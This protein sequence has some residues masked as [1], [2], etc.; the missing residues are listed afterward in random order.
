MKKIVIILE[1]TEA[2]EI[3]LASLAEL[4]P[5]FEI[6]AASKDTNIPDMEVDD[7]SSQEVPRTN[8]VMRNEE[9]QFVLTSSLC[10]EQILH[11]EV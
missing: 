1:K 8:N 6:I 9:K 10:S 3:L 7:P 5:E 11:H 2:S 4:F